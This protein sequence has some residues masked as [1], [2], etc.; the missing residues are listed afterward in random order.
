MEFFSVILRY[1][2]F[3][4]IGWNISSSQSERLNLNSMK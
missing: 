3:E 1:A 4:T 2:E